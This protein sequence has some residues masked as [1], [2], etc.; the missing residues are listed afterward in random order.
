MIR[1]ARRLVQLCGAAMVCLTLGVSSAS[2]ATVD[3]AH[4][5]NDISWPQ[6]GKALPTGQAFGIVGINGGLANNTNPCFGAELDWANR[7]VRTTGQD[8]AALYVNTANPGLTGSWWPTS[9]EYPVGSGNYVQVPAQYAGPCTGQDTAACAYVYGYAKAY[10]DVKLRLG[11]AP[12][13][14]PA[15]SYLWWLDVETTNSWET[16]KTANL[17]DLEGM[18]SYFTGISARVGIYSTGYQWAVIT[19]T[20]KSTPLSGLPDWVPGARSLKGAQSNCKSTAFT[21]GSRITV[22]QYTSGLLDYDWSCI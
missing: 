12:Q 13:S 18:T 10:D 4:V 5:G 6:C 19:G 22:T 16:N 8:A 20:P 15:A 11:T 2:A 7:S 1:L 17:A 21:P 14:A 9:N 3:P